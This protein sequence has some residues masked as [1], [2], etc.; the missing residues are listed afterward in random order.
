MAGKT[1]TYY[2][3]NK[4]KAA[5]KLR[6]DLNYQK[7]GYGRKSNILRKRARRK[8][9]KEGPVNGDVEH[10]IPLSKGGSNSDSNLTVMDPSKNRGKDRPT[11]N[12]SK[13]T[14]KIL[15]T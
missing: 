11:K 8:K 3:E 15:T 10:I 13:A 7:T 14:A 2:N 9:E 5:D 4:D 1:Q 12:K 6:Y